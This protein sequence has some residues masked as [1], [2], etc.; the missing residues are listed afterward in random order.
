[1]NLNARELMLALLT[2]V[3]VL[4]GVTFYVGKAKLGEW[5]EK[6]EEAELLEQKLERLQAMYDRK[7]SIREGFD[8][9]ISTL[10]VHP[11]DMDVTADS[12]QRIQ[13]LARQHQLTLRSMDSKD[14]KQ[15][16]DLNLYELG[17]SCD[18]EGSLDAI[19]RFLYAIQ[20]DKSVM[21]IRQFDI[22]RKPRTAGE[23]KGKFMVDCAYLRGNQTEESASTAE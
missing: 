4:F 19:V 15:V 3:V 12:L 9:L 11:T 1:M 23:F 17:I 10:P 5:Q 13:D 22:A 20:T 2:L 7:D 21:D 14:E 8:R 6:R 16:G 18:Y